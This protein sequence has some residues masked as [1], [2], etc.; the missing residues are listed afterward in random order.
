MYDVLYMV[1]FVVALEVKKASSA[2]NR[3]RLPTK[4]IIYII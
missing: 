4:Y 1:F 2:Q 3:G